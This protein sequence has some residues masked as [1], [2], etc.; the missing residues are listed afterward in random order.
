MSS[1]PDSDAE[2]VHLALETTGV[3]LW[4][5]DVKAGLI[6]W[7]RRMHELTGCTEPLSPDRYQ[8]YVHPEDRAMMSQAMGRTFEQRTF[9]SAPHRFVRPDGQVRWMQTFGKVLTDGDG[10]PTRIVGG[11]LDVTEQ[12][13]LAESFRAAHR[14][15]TVG[16]LAAGISHNFN[17]LLATMLPAI[18]L[19]LRVTEGDIHKALSDAETAGRR[20]ADLVRQVMTWSKDDRVRDSPVAD[21]DQL[22]HRV[23]GMCRRF[24]E[25]HFELTVATKANGAGVRCHLA[26]L[27]QALMNLLVNARDALRDANSRMPR[28][29]VSAELT[30]PE[31]VRIRVVDNGP[32]MTREVQA[33]LFE[34]F[35]TTK[36]V[37][38]G[39]G[40]GLST[41]LATAQ[42]HGGSVRYDSVLGVGST[43]ELFLPVAANVPAQTPAPTFRR[44]SGEVVLIVDDEAPVRRAVARLLERHG[45][46]VVQAE[47]GARAVELLRQDTR[48][49]AVLLDQAMP[50][51]PGATVAP[52]LRAVRPE[53]S[54]LFHTGHEVPQEHL[55]LAD[56]VLL[57][58]VTP[59]LLLQALQRR[60]KR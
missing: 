42:R 17:N 30:S 45:Y 35:F 22:V 33:H 5:F 56:E 24:F 1:L 58:P 23:V 34:P 26:E 57:K 20:A 41:V 14:L 4:V 43:F 21:V 29:D 46:E 28:I 59:D 36:P 48:I 25:P 15:E 40:L 44:S 49:K 55:A 10:Q 12:H 31:T 53:V 2:L 37:G 3:G 18:E 51:G 19:A 7:N 54:I 13:Q 16:Q 8:T 50:F 38:S 11:N 60:T 39:T 6:Q 32:G 52:K 27:E 47:D 9:T